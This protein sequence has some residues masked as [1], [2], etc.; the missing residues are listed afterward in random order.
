VADKICNVFISHIHE[1]DHRLQPLK[2]LLANNGCEARDS[3]VSSANPNRAKDPDY[4]MNGILKPRIDWA[5]TV[6]VLVT[7]D[8]KNSQWVNDE[9]EY[10][11]QKD[12]KIVGIW[13]QGEK[14]CELPAALE[15]YGD[16]VV[17]WRG[18]QIIDAIFNRIEGWRDPNGNPMAPRTIPHHRC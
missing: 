13:D 12:K 9:I 1:D 4:I 15:Q 17:A 6:V 14:G 11:H 8:T 10:A 2:E 18:D 3:S 16:H 7:P 5:G